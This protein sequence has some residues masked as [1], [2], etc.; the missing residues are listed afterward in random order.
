MNFPIYLDY[1][2]TTPIDP[3][4]LAEMLPY[5]TTHFG[6]P[7][8]SSHAY[9]WLAEEAITTATE[10]IATSL[11]CEKNEILFTSGAT[12]SI[13]LGIKGYLD[14]NTSHN[15]IITF[16]TEHK[17]TLDTLFSLEKKGFK[18]KYLPVNN[19]GTIDLEL[20]E[21]SISS[22]TALVS[23]MLVNNETGII[24]PVKT[25]T[26]IAKKQRVA[27]HC[28]AAQA[29]GK[30]PVSFLELDVDLLS[31]SGHKI[32]APKG[33]GGLI[34]KKNTLLSAQIVGGGQQRNYRSGTLNVPG[35]V[36][37]GKAT[38]L[39]TKNQPEEYIRIN[40]LASEFSKSLTSQFSYCK[41]NAES[42]PRVP[43]I[44]NVCFNN[45]DG[46]ELLM[47][48]NKIAI[49]NGSAC[50]AATQLPSHVL[51]AMGMSNTEAFGSLRF[52]FGRMTTVN[53]VND[54]KSF[55]FNVLMTANI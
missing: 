36:A 5:L 10:R 45:L 44:L 28:D 18:V 13:N 20:F 48:L 50:N 42:S 24:N 29:I 8:S 32:Y 2:A 38:D 22:T 52:S 7:A 4:V 34:V 12:E 14:A 53:E 33:I 31:F 30:I 55:L 51:I 25:I 37:I 47:K 17:A 3:Q 35:I 21:K 49:S 9:G 43:H 39:A 40:K 15:E 46:E 19:N 41:I 11:K 6:N 26:E 16:K 27:V 54:A 1:A 23:L